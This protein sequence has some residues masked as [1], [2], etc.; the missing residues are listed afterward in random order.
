MDTGK[1][2]IFQIK[3]YPV[4]IYCLLAFSISWGFK[5]LYTLTISNSNLP[6][7]N[8]GLIAQF[9]PSIAAIILIILSEGNEG[10]KRIIKSL[11]FWRTGFWWLLLAIFFEPI[12]FFTIT[13]FY[14]LSNGDINVNEGFILIP[15]ILSLISTFTIGLLRWGIAEEIGWK[16]WLLL[17]L[18]SSLS[19]FTAAMISAIIITF[20]HL[21][22]N[23]L[24]E[25][26][27]VFK[28]GTYIWGYYSNVVERLIISIP[29]TLVTVYIFNQT[30]GSLLL[31]VLFHSASNTS[32]FWIA[33]S[34]GI[35]G[36]AFFKLFFLISLIVIMMLFS[37]L[38]IRQK[39][40][41][42]S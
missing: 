34:F 1:S 13:I 5:Y 6:I 12:L 7:F 41:I 16:G 30:K 19:P 42:T 39:T 4:L 27:F 3:K 22:P 29:I 40:K 28:D 21:S 14:W 11:T 37:F 25:D 24:A 15:G 23:T 35:V 2:Y 20:W 9:G 10:L 38:V 33:E 26:I 36:I 8:V 31:M 32:Y 17:K 18:Q